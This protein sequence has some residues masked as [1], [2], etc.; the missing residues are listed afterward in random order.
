MCA[1]PYNTYKKGTYSSPEFGN[2]LLHWQE[3]FTPLGEDNSKYC[4]TGRSVHRVQARTDSER[5]PQWDLACSMVGNPSQIHKDH[6]DH[7]WADHEILSHDRL[8]CILF[9]ISWCSSRR[10]FFLGW[11][12]VY[13]IALRMLLQTSSWLRILAHMRSEYQTDFFYPMS[14]FNMQFSMRLFGA[15][16]RAG[17]GGSEL[18]L[19]CSF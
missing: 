10:V 17:T 7:I 2:S 6:I 5:P 11:L 8:G 12:R 3:G 13:A 18:Y 16:W 14:V 9:V 15:S 4:R 1:E 19:L